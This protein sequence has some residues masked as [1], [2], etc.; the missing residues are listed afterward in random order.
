MWRSVARAVAWATIAAATASAAATTPA[1]TASAVSAS[2]AAGVLS[3]TATA[4]TAAVWATVA[5]SKILAAAIPA[6]ARR[7]VLRGVVVRRKILRSGGVGL[8]LLFVREIA[9]LAVKIFV[10]FGGQGIDRR[11]DVSGFVMEM[12]F[13]GNFAFT[14][15]EMLNGSQIPQMLE[16]VRGERSFFAIV[17]RGV[18]GLAGEQFDGGDSCAV[19]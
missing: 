6:A 1:A 2:V 12:V 9:V 13:R 14:A 17:V 8:R 16:L 11:G 7:I 10:M 18:E 3:A 5:A 19:G 15:G 4:I